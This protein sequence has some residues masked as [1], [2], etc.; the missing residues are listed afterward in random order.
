MYKDLTVI[1]PTL[2]EGKNIGK[3]IKLVNSKYKGIKIIVSDDGSKDNTK[4]ICEKYK[5]VTFL[6]R[7]KNKV[8]GL[9]ASV[10]DGI[11]KTK[12]K[13][14]VCMD[15]DLQHPPEKLGEFYEKFK[16]GCL[17]IY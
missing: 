9:T 13:Y 2:N 8:K 1:V 3:L 10:V 16:L 14:F 4:Q 11:N 7:S 12:T 15:G 6:D 5:N 17:T